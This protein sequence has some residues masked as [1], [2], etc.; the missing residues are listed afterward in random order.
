MQIGELGKRADVSAKAIRYY[1]EIGIVPE[2]ERTPSGYRDYDESALQRLRFIKAAQAVS[3]SLGEIREILA[4]RDR[5]E[6]PCAHV[7]ELM[8]QRVATLSEHIRGLEQM[9]AELQELVVK[10][11]TLPEAC[12]DGYCHI[13]ENAPKR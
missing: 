7:S 13:I 4:F 5:G 12:G 8:N 1:E 6:I 3:L 9:R 11:K 10:A 2:P